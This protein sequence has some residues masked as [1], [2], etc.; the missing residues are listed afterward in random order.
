MER[1]IRQGLPVVIRWAKAR[2][3]TNSLGITAACLFPA[4]LIGCGFSLN[5]PSGAPGSQTTGGSGGGGPVGQ[6]VSFPTLTQPLTACEN[7]NT[8]PSNGDWGIGSNPVFVNPWN[9]VVGSPVYKSN[10]IFW[11]SRETAP[12]QSILLT[13]AFTDA[14]KNIRIAP[15]PAGT[16][17]W[18]TLV[19]HSTTVISPTQQSTTGLSFL[20]PISFPAGVYG[21]QIEDPSA[22]PV[23]SL[24]N[25]P[26]LNW[27]IGVPATVDP[28]TA[29][30]HQVYDC[31]VEPGG[32][33]RVFGK[34]FIPPNQVVLQSS[35]GIAYA[36]TP[37]KLDSN[38]LAAVV[39]SGLPPGTYNLW[40][41]TSPWGATSSPVAQIVVKT[42]PSM[43]VRNVA[44]STLVGDGVTDNTK[45]LQSCLD[46]Y[47]PIPGSNELAY[48]TLPAGGPFV[49]TGG[50]TAHPFEFLGG[51][52]SA[53]TSFLGRPLSSPPAAW[54]T[55]PPHFGMANVSLQAPANPNLLLSAGSTS[56][57]PFTSGHLFFDNINFASTTGPSN[58]GELMFVVAGP[59]IQIYNST[60]LSNSNQDFDIYFGDG[61][62]ISGNHFVLN[63]WTGLE[64]EDSQNV[65]FENNL[66]DSA[67]ATGQGVGGT[68]AGSGLSV[69]RGNSVWGPSAVSRDVYVGYNTFQNMGSQSQQVVLNDGDGGSYYGPI[70]SSSASTVTLAAD[71]WW[72]WMGTTNPQA[73]SMAIVSGT[74]VGQ[75][76]FLQSYS[77]R[78]ITLAT[79]W[80]VQ[81]D[82]TSVVAI[83]QYELYMTWAHNIMTNTLGAS[84]VL[85]DA[86][87]SVVEDNTLTNSGAGIYLSAFGPYG[88]P[89]S[90]GPVINT[91]V[92][93]NTL[94]VGAGNDIWNNP[95]SNY[96]GIGIQDMPGCLFSGLMIRD[97]LV[98]ARNTIFSTNGV[99]GISAIVIEQNQAYMDFMFP[100][101]GFL[102]QDNSPPA[103]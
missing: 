42:T 88:G 95:H 47:A 94:R 64:I 97:N 60:F 6:T 29:L 46:Q 80:K 43:S 44:C 89:A 27:A 10:T 12:G 23:M 37:T 77:G 22:P 33:L 79:P 2:F 74:G 17:D 101:P 72:A 20:V 40:V 52:P 31:G 73:A 1:L 61:A 99:N 82:G 13:G 102:I 25:V 96:S 62:I 36:L 90:Y 16:T 32:I 53:V 66:T 76:S 83:T 56:G 50:V 92:L 48:I 68:S 54:F 84:F 24:A 5:T 26:A 55:I 39:P 49:L 21:F 78:T 63:N 81:P 91:D 67:Q 35:T 15:V 14:T 69:S 45:R 30:T 58:N 59:D 103:D 100:V 51:P 57:D 86:L 65:I 8:G 70:S 28:T 75:Y 41:G 7:P 4:L 11:T 85:A 98:P 3:L 93:R 71:P 34:N 9:V 18:Q 38:S 87:E 19:T